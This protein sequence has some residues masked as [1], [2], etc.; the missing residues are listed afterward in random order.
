MKNKKTIQF[1]WA[2]WV[3]LSTA[4]NNETPKFVDNVVLEKPTLIWPANGETGVNHTNV[5]LKW[6]V[7]PELQGEDYDYLGYVG[8]AEDTSNWVGI[9]LGDEGDYAYWPVVL[10]H[11]KTYYWQVKMYDPD[12]RST[13]SEKRSFTTGNSSFLNPNLLYDEFTDSRDGHVYKTI[14]IGD[15]VWMA[16]NLAYLPKLTHPEDF[17]RETPCYA[18]WLYDGNS[19]EEAKS[20]MPVDIYK[21]ADWDGDGV[22]ETLDRVIYETYGVIYNW[23]AATQSCP[24][25]WKLP[26]K[27]DWAKLTGNEKSLSSIKGWS[28]KEGYKATNSTGFSAIS[29]TRV[30]DFQFQNNGDHANA[31]WWSASKE[32]NPYGAPINA[33]YTYCT[34][35]NY[36]YN[37]T[38]GV[39]DGHNVRC[40]KE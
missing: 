1:L 8:E 13:F 30:M 4:C 39:E 20:F 15:Q 6:E 2:I 16:E 38:I 31:S 28:V 11:N 19:V 10:E 37:R 17:S 35:Y 3:L 12:N 27:A 7:K 29:G 25:G 9:P 40:I 23:K 36:E 26:T 34:Q 5:F 14:E 21:Q 22:E 24:D 32:Y 18:V 33:Y